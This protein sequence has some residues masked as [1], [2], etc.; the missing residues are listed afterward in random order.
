VT[1]KRFKFKANPVSL[2]HISTMKTAFFTLFL[3]SQCA[4]LSQ[5]WGPNTRWIYY[6]DEFMPA[7]GD[8]YLVIRHEKDTLIQGLD[9][10][11]FME[12]AYQIS[13]SGTQMDSAM[14]RQFIL[15]WQDE[16]VWFYEPED[17]NFYVI[18]D[19]SLGVGDTLYAYGSI[20]GVHSLVPLIIMDISTTQIGSKTLKVQ[21]V[22]QSEPASFNMDGALIEEIGSTQHLLP[23]PGF[24]DPPPGGDLWCYVN[25]DFQYPVTG[26]CQLI[27]STNTAIDRQ[28]VQIMPNPAHDIVRV[29]TDTGILPENIE[30][31]STAGRILAT[32]P[33]DII[34]VSNIPSGIYLLKISWNKYEAT[35]SKLLRL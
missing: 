23:R 16:K 10:D 25:N 2:Q 28:I 12:L 24:V 13:A 29:R 35:F 9:C 33:G 1:G 17:S 21:H 18:Y 7:P 11:Q 14:L 19:F 4:L 34:D 32:N 8:R 31:F 30:I 27:L 3:L 6:Q 15:H 5:T 20:S 22:L 26:A